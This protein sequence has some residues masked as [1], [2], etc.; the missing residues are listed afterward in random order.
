M[1]SK[2]RQRKSSKRFD[3]DFEYYASDGAKW[4]RMLHIK[5]FPQGAMQVDLWLDESDQEKLKEILGE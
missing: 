5:V 2:H 4:Q 1:F 3:F